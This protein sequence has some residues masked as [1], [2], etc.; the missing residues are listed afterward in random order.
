MDRKFLMLTALLSA[1]MFGGVWV[2]TA[3]PAQGDTAA[4]TDVV[5]DT[6]AIEAPAIEASVYYPGCNAVRAAGKAPLHRGEPGYRD[7]MDGDGDGIACEAYSGD[8]GGGG[9]IGHRRRRP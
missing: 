5:S 7:E 2:A 1:G 4:G 8:G 6:S 3:P 9:Y